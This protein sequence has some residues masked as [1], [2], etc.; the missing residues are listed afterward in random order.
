MGALILGGL[1][2]L[3]GLLFGG[4]RISQPDMTPA[5]LSD[6]QVNQTQEGTPIPLCYGEVVIPSTIIWYGNLKVEEVKRKVGGGKKG[7]KEV[8]TGYK[9][10]LDILHSVATTGGSGYY[11]L[12]GIYE[13]DRVLWEGEISVSG[14]YSGI[15]DSDYL[16]VG[17]GDLNS[18]ILPP[19]NL[20]N[21]PPPASRLPSLLWVFS[22][23][24]YIGFNRTAVPTLKFRV[25]RVLPDFFSA[26]SNLST[27]N[28]PIAVIYD[29]LVNQIGINPKSIDLASFDE[30][31]N[32]YAS[33]NF[34]INLAITQSDRL[35]NII[36]RILEWINAILYYT[37][38]GL[39]AI[40]SLDQDEEPIATIQDEFV[41]FGISKHTI[42]ELPNIFRAQLVENG[43][44]AM[45]S[46]E[47][48]AMK[49]LAGENNVK[50]FDLTAIGNRGLALERLNQLM[51]K[52]SFP[53][54]VLTAKLPIKWAW[55]G[56]GDVIRVIN[57]DWGIDA[58]FRIV[59][60]EDVDETSA[61][62]SIRA[63]QITVNQFSTEVLPP[64]VA[65]PSEITEFVPLLDPSIVE[66]VE[67]PTKERTLL[68]LIPRISDTLLGYSVSISRDGVSYQ[69][70]GFI[71]T[72]SG[73]Y[74]LTADYPAT[75]YDVDTS[76]GILATPIYRDEDYEIPI[77][78]ENALS[79][80]R[81]LY[82]NG[83]FMSF[84]DFRMVDAQTVAFGTIVRGL[85]YSSKANHS[86][87]GYAYISELGNN[88]I[89]I[90][91][92]Y[93]NSFILKFTPITPSIVHED[94]A[95]TKEIALSG[96]GS[97]PLPIKRVLINASSEGV[98]TLDV[99]SEVRP[100]LAGAGLKP[101][102]SYTD[103]YPFEPDGYVVING[104]SFTSFNGIQ[105]SVSDYPATLTLY[106]IKNGIQGEEITIDIPSEGVYVWNDGELVE[107]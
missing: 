40:K 20:M 76:T 99:F 29:L 92:E 17:N 97:Q 104:Q 2:L 78:F 82:A 12:L 85:L 6:F 14:E 87:G 23:R 65:T 19:I 81:F 105:V 64:A 42:K 52:Y 45:V 57:T 37:D 107:I 106:R 73:V 103:T 33:K 100:P 62:F 54:S 16:V 30:L 27:G 5:S 48:P 11:K 86:T 3:M 88:Q 63:I 15:A 26:P 39:I 75:T 43:Q 36:Q 70:I 89:V 93:G 47:N 55:L 61:D 18:N 96:K 101:E 102:D 49:S 58:N 21:P 94:K 91:E 59:E 53:A 90:P 69:H 35:E 13:N 25:Y 46:A 9:Y 28:N 68:V 31:A 8:L 44:V 56:V 77:P 41:S 79:L 7:S 84:S 60:V 98:I 74:Q 32:Y 67:L 22:R 66:I 95:F 1:A 4:Q 50:V 80:D 51:Q 24:Y 10:Y 83:E 71:S 38:E 34:G 72:F